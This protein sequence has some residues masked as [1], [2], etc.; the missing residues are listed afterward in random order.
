MPPVILSS[1]LVP[2]ENAIS[3]ALALAPLFRLQDSLDQLPEDHPSVALP[4][5]RLAKR[6]RLMDAW[7]V[8]NRARKATTDPPTPAA[9]A[10]GNTTAPAAS[11]KIPDSGEND[12][13]APEVDT[14]LPMPPGDPRSH[15]LGVAPEASAASGKVGCGSEHPVTVWTDLPYL[16]NGETGLTRSEFRVLESGASPQGAD[17][18]WASRSID[19]KFEA[20]MG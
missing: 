18:L 7:A 17:V 4:K 15:Q 14:S 19:R 12:I 11:Q 1:C 3:R 13:V 20:A 16:W 5:N 6:Q 9:I 2:S 8:E 10:S